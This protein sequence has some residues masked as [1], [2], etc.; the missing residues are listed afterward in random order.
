[1]DFIIWNKTEKICGNLHT[2][3][4]S[5]RLGLLGE[6]PGAIDVDCRHPELIPVPGSQRVLE[7]DVGPD[8]AVS[9]DPAAQ[10][11]RREVVTHVMTLLQYVQH[12]VLLQGRPCPLYHHGATSSSF[13]Y[14]QVPRNRWQP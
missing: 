5:E 1:M 6:P 8:G 14:R 9:R 12:R 13:R 10:P 3:R 11:G 2:N 7:G 4:E